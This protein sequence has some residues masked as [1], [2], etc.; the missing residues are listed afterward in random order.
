[1]NIALA[2]EDHHQCYDD[3][4]LD[5][6]ARF[7]TTV[8]SLS[9]L[10]VSVRDQKV[11]LIHQ[12]AKEFLLAK[13]DVATCGWKHSLIPNESETLM[14][15]ICMT[16][17]SFTEFDGATDRISVAVKYTYLDYAASFW[18]AHYRIAQHG[19][20]E[21]ML[22]LVLRICDT[23]CQ[24]FKTW[25][26]VYWEMAG[27]WNIDPEFTSILLVA[28]YFGHEAVVRRLLEA[29]ADVEAKDV[30]SRTPL[31]WAAKNGHE[32]VVRLLLEAE[33]DVEA[34]DPRLGWT[35][36]SW[37]AKKGHEA[38]VRLL[39]EAEADVEAKDWLGRTP[40]LWAAKNGHEAVVRLLLEAEADVEAK[41]RFSRTPLSE[42]AKKEHEAVVRLLLEA[43]ADAEAKNGFGETP[44]SEA[45]GNGHEAVVRLLLEAEADVEAKNG[46]GQTPLS[47]AAGNGHE[48]V[49]RLL[50]SFT[51]PIPI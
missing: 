15:R 40:L 35:P 47:V 43:D 34:K 24:R 51:Q 41:D 11:Y 10:F 1:M 5:D 31:S 42:A 3:L 21:Y 23:Q 9:G 39:L 44:L 26:K 27:Q 33:A 13:S 16:H 2:I 50:R 25:F 22:Q 45:A 46:F 36:L 30:F 37:A 12:T 19:A 17:L 32:A 8:K 7:E 4:D 28:S 18:A 48:A 29:D 6:E 49:V 14:A 20:T 38:V